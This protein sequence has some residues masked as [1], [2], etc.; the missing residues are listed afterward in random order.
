MEVYIYI[1]IYNATHVALVQDAS[2]CALA[3]ITALRHRLQVATVVL[4]LILLRC[5]YISPLMMCAD[6]K[7]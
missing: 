5:A 2:R 4:K 1:Y 7:T 3:M 6:Q